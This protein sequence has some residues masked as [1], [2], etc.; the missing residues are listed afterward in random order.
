MQL[1]SFGFAGGRDEFR[2]FY[3]LYPAT[4]SPIIVALVT[5]SLARSLEELSDEEVV[6]KAL[7][8]L[9]TIYGDS[10]RFYDF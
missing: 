5:G 3:N 7:R 10:V 9:R 2:W 1:Y 6:N 8:A 4:R